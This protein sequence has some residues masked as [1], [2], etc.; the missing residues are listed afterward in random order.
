MLLSCY[1][2]FV[3]SGAQVVIKGMS[4][5]K[6]RE[7]SEECNKMSLNGVEVLRVVAD[8]T[9]EEDLKRLINTIVQTYGRIDIQVTN[10]E[11]VVAVERTGPE[12]MMS[13]QLYWTHTVS[14]GIY[15]TCV[16]HLAKIK[17]NIV[18]ISGV[19]SQIPVIY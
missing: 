11:M 9:E 17:G 1:I 18:N 10:F 12:Y 6:V 7:V 8:V 5:E 14:S 4:D 19:F 3:S 15:D 13:K 2:I 16:K